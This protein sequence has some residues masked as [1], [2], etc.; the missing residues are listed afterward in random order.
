[1]T[2]SGH[3]DNGL[4]TAGLGFHARSKLRLLEILPYFYVV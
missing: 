4:I 3:A 1:V 2:V